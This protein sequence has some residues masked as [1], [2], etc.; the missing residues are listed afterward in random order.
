MRRIAW[1]YVGAV[2]VLGLQLLVVACGPGK[3]SVAPSAGGVDSSDAG[4]SSGGSAGKASTGG[5]AGKAN[6]G[7]S[8]TLGGNSGS[9]DTTLD[10]FL[11][12]EGDGF[13]AR[14]F[15]CVEG[16]DD[17]TT[18]RLLLKT[19]QGCKDLLARVNANNH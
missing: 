9:G 12:S 16:N 17:F 13:C 5:S 18:Q 8:S 3:K 7:G 15:R 19:E 10:T 2:G 4:Q 14:L 6:T 1:V 11:E